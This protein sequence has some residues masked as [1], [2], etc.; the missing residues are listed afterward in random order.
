MQDLAIKD[1]KNIKNK[2]WR[3]EIKKKGKIIDKEI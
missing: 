2:Y 3:M 1:H